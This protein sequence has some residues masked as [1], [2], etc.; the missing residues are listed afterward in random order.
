MDWFGTVLPL[1][2][3]PALAVL[4][5][6]FAA[7][8]SVLFRN[9]APG[10]AEDGTTFEILVPIYGDTKYLANIE[11][12][13]AYGNSVIFCTTNG[14]TQEFNAS[15]QR[16]AAAHGF[17]IFQSNYAAPPS[18]GRRKTGGT[19]RDRVVRDALESVVT[20]AYVV[21]MDA[22]TTSS[23][24]LHELVGELS[25][26]GD[27]VASVELIPQDRGNGLV[28][29]QR[30]EYRLAMRLRYVVPWLLSGA[31]HA[32]RSTAMRRIMAEHSLFF[33]GNDVET[34]L[35]AERLGYRVTHIPF[36]VHTDVPAT[37]RS[38]WRQRLAWSGGEFRLYVMNM[39]F[40]FWHPFFWAY[41]AVVLFGFFLL[42]WAALLYPGWS[43]VVA[44]VLYFAMVYGVHWRNRNRWLLLMPFYTLVTSLILLPLGVVWYLAMAVPEK[45]F[46]IIR[47]RRGHTDRSPVESLSGRRGAAPAAG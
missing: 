34:G 39:R 33:Q 35:I 18:N 23:R 10:A 46:G 36:P 21:C 28:Q 1:L 8:R 11:Y 13:R 17:R 25:R 27:D 26:R 31:C 15:L 37:W 24:P 4:I 44:G 16:I 19:I 29:L 22:D 14:E 7:G 47:F 41:G 40:S 9:R 32:G 38:W 30:H 20:A 42:R 6:G 45:N 5:D 43:L 2:L 12:L 3:L